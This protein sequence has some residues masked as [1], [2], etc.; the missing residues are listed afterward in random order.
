[1]S[2]VEDDEVTS[3]G[4]NRLSHPKNRGVFAVV[5]DLIA[6]SIEHQR[7]LKELAKAIQ[8]ADQPVGPLIIQRIA[9]EV[10]K[11]ADSRL[12]HSLKLKSLTDEG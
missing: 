3:P 2:A 10:R 6:D 7:A 12:Q 9:E 1:M 5:C 11:D 4:V 8:A